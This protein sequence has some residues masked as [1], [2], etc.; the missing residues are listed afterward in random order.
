[1]A[2]D[3][4]SNIP[5]CDATALVDVGLQLGDREG[6]HGIVLVPVNGDG[7]GLHGHAQQ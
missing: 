4:W 6:R 1:M 3:A 2:S 5:V 7:D